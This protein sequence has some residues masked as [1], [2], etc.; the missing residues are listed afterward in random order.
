[1][2]KCKILHLC[3]TCT[4][5]IDPHQNAVRE[6]KQVHPDTTCRVPLAWKISLVILYLPSHLS[7]YEM[8]K[9]AKKRCRLN[10]DCTDITLQR[11]TF[12]CRR[13][14]QARKRRQAECIENG[15]RTKDH[16]FGTVWH[17]FSKCAG[18]KAVRKTKYNILGSWGQ[19][20]KAA[21]FASF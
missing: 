5:A 3:T 16:H 21:R 7:I 11:L 4:N 9:N 19:M 8:R 6:H 13:P 17:S 15:K 20:L 2:H 14:P 10:F 18:I 12:L 1:M